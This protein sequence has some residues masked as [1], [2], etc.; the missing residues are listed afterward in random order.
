VVN[1]LHFNAILIQVLDNENGF[2][3]M[4]E[5]VNLKKKT[6]DKLIKK[7]NQS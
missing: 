6:K 2:E 3:N 7:H 4:W 5:V 1:I